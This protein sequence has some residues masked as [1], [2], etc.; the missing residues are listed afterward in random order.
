MAQRPN[1]VIITTD[2]QRRDSLSCY[3]SDFTSTPNLDRLGAEGAVF[4]RAYCA[5]PVCTPARASIFSGL[6]VSR[7]GTWN[8]GMKVPS[9]IPFLSHRLHDAGYGTHYVGKAH[10][11]PFQGDSVEN[12]QQL[13]AEPFPYYGFDGA[14]LSMGHTAYG[15]GGHYG[16]W[17]RQQIGEVALD[18]LGSRSVRLAPEPWGGEG[19]DWA[20]PTAL[21]SSV[22]TAQRALAFL[23]V[24][25]P[26][27]PFF[28]AVGFQDP[29]HPH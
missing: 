21:H 15:F 17:V 8:V 27:Q 23:E 24:Q 20:L 4:E 11:E 18:A 26:A 19:Y 25:S 14:E 1:V 9:D 7:H 22:W 29:H 6:Q 16:T 2:Q 12:L 5:N 3:G 13:Y 28:L 10:F